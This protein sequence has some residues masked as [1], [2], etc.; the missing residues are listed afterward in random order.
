MSEFLRDEIHRLAEHVVKERQRIVV[1]ADLA[2][3]VDDGHR[4][5]P[6][7][8]PRRSQCGRRSRLGLV[9]RC[10]GRRHVDD[11]ALGLSGISMIIEILRAN[12]GA[13]ISRTSSSADAEAWATAVTVTS[14]RITPMLLSNVF[15]ALILSASTTSTTLPVCLSNFTALTAEAVS[16]GRLAIGLRRPSSSKRS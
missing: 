3:Q 6:D 13:D 15:A 14:S 1:G 8:L 2:R 7:T 4:H 9:D 16:R 5:G 10:R 11:V 12:S